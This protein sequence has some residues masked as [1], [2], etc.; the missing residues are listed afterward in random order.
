[1]LKIYE[2]NNENASTKTNESMNQGN[3]IQKNNSNSSNSNKN[4]VDGCT[5]GCASVGLVSLIL[6]LILAII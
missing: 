2:N 5:K 3:S 1:M 6:G 4:N